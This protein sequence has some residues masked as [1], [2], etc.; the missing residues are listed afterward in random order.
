MKLPSFPQHEVSVKYATEHRCGVVVRGAGLTDAI[1]GTDP[2]KDNLPL[3]KSKPEDDTTEVSRS[4]ECATVAVTGM[5][6]VE[7][8]CDSLV[9]ICVQDK[10]GLLKH[11][12]PAVHGFKLLKH[13][14]TTCVIAATCFIH[15]P[16]QHGWLL[17]CVL[18]YGLQAKH[19]AA[20]VNELSGE[21][22]KI[23]ENHPINA[24]RRAEGKN[25]ANVVLLRG[26]GSRINVDSFEQLH[27]MK[28]CLVAPTKIIAGM[29]LF[30]MMN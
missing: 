29:S 20:V 17:C 26:C 10:L 1:S 6:C 16:L 12:R 21:M 7:R 27:G 28:A 22:M 18:T 9:Q 11:T 2:L 14:L 24:Q 8:Q 13:V 3:L 30:M 15:L 5:R 25:P 4:S 23:L 19:T